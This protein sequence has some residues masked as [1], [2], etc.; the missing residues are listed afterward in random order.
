MVRC[1][2]L[3]ALLLVL[4]LALRTGHGLRRLDRRFPH[5]MLAETEQALGETIEDGERILV[6][7]D[8]T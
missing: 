6:E 5:R 3:R 1:S 7:E 2:G 8:A 4:A